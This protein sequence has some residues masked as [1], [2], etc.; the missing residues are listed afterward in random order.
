M[1][2]V[3]NQCDI[4]YSL[5]TIF[6]KL[7]VYLI[8][9]VQLCSDYSQL[10]SSTTTHAAGGF[11]AGCR[12]YRLFLL[13]TSSFWKAESGNILS[14]WPFLQKG[15]SHRS[16]KTPKGMCVLV[17]VLGVRI[18][19]FPLKQ[20]KIKSQEEKQKE[21]CNGNRIDSLSKLRWHFPFPVN[22]GFNYMASCDS[23]IPNKPDSVGGAKLG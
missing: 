7:S 10:Q 15:A 18:Y 17:Y 14:K 13:W 16:F 6:S 8:S 23:L 2:F 1:P 4:A 20:K 19:C 11:W 12:A 3:N 22:Y 21:G 9:G 5:C